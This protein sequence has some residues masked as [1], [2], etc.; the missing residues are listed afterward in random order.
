MKVSKSEVELR[1]G[2]PSMSI[3]SYPSDL[4]ELSVAR[5][6]VNGRHPNEEGAQFIEHKCN[7]LI[8]VIKGEGKVIIDGQEF[9]VKAEETVTIPSGQ[10]YYII[11]NVDYIAATSPTYSR[12]QNEVI[13]ANK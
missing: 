5:I 11:G 12:E 2:S 1:K 3:K 13:K 4:K 9:E 6:W 10:K 8:Y 7:V